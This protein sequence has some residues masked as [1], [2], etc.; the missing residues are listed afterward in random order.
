MKTVSVPR[1]LQQQPS[2]S[3]GKSLLSAERQ[4]AWEKWQEIGLPG[5]HMEGWKYTNLRGLNDLSPISPVLDVPN[6]PRIQGAVTAV[7]VDGLFRSDLS[8]F[9][10][11][12]AGIVVKGLKQALKEFPDLYTN[13]YGQILKATGAVPSEHALVN[14]NAAIF[15]DGLFIHVPS[16]VKINR[17]FHIILCGLA[18]VRYPRLLIK[19]EEG[20]SLEIIET[21]MGEGNGFTNLVAEI[22]VAK[23]ASLRHLIIQAESSASFHVAYQASRLAQD[24]QYK[25]FILQQ[26]ARLARR[27]MGV[28]LG[29]SE[30]RATLDAL[31]MGSAGNHLDLTSFI[32]H[33]APQTL[34]DSVVRMVLGENARGVFQGKVLVRPDSQKVDGNQLAKALLLSRSAE[35]D[36]K[37]ELEIYADDVKC[38][39]GAAVGELDEAQLFYLMTRG[40]SKDEARQL[41][42]QA[43]FAEILERLP[44]G[45]LRTVA[46]AQVSA[47]LLAAWKGTPS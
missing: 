36:I 45:I 24:A 37:P 5:P 46:E 10:D 32:D 2:F 20:S 1:I 21:S 15:S 29:G 16:N 9:N 17:P 8:D 40:L 13:E 25:A 31:L 41:L 12:P 30:A 47:W 42:I 43:F 44:E 4:E 35:A 18:T 26:G 19:I 3:E 6:L 38:S 23:R 27:E 34:S 11:L 28:S 33:A 7:L 14:L 39:H 22:D